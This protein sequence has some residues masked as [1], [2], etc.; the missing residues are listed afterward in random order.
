MTSLINSKLMSLTLR[1]T[2]NVAPFYSYLSGFST[3]S[4]LNADKT[5]DGLPKRPMNAFMRFCK[6]VRPDILSRNP[7]LSPAQVTSLLGE[8]YR[9]LPLSQKEV[10]LIFESRKKRIQ[11]AGNFGASFLQENFIGPS[12]LRSVAALNPSVGKSF[13]L[14][15]LENKYLRMPSLS[16]LFLKNI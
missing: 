6:D 2:S 8:R 15:D 11:V 7:G 4:S 12:L 14:Q 9:A 3:N 16:R 10:S 5:S 13:V 1:S